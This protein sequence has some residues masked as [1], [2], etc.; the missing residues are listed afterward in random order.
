[1]EELRVRAGGGG[2]GVAQARRGQLHARRGHLRHRLVTRV[3][4]AA[5]ARRQRQSRGGDGAR[6]RQH[7]RRR[8]GQGVGRAREGAHVRAGR[9]E[10]ALAPRQR[11]PGRA[12]RPAGGDGG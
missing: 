10:G 8:G 7:G 3:A 5:A 1:M 6:R 2:V 4:A 9:R 11:R 12:E